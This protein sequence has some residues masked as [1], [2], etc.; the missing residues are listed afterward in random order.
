MS[1]LLTEC[2]AKGARIV[3]LKSG[4][5]GIF[6]RLEEELDALREAGIAYEIVPGGSSAGAAAAAA[7]I[8][9]T[10]RPS[11]RRLQIVTASDVS[12]GLPSDLNWAALADAQAMTAVF[13]GKR[14]FP[15]LA[16]RLVN[17]GLAES[18]PAILAESLGRSS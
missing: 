18:A 14:T 9:L 2:A 5:A 13:M 6:G 7:G 8:L 11:S 10:R 16:N 1:R 12:D 17:H 4:D 15:H 3:R